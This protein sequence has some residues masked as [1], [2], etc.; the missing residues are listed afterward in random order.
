MKKE[1]RKSAG[2]IKIDNNKVGESNKALAARPYT[3]VN[4]VEDSNTIEAKR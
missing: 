1:T 4:M 3:S 2:V